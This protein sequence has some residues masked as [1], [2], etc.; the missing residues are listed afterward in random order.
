LLNPLISV[1]LFD[2]VFLEETNSY[3]EERIMKRKFIAIAMTMTMVMSLSACGKSAEVDEPAVE[4][5]EEVTAEESVEASSEEEK[6][7]EEQAAEVRAEGEALQ[8]EME[9]AGEFSV[10]TV[11][12]NSYVNEYFGVKLNLL[13]GYAFVDDEAL[14]QITGL[15]ADMLSDN[16]LLAKAIEDG[17]A[18][19]IAYAADSTGLNNVNV[20]VQSN[21]SLANAI[22]DEEAVLVASVGQ[23]KSALEAQGISNITYDVVEKEVAGEN[24]K[25]LKMNGEFNGIE[26]HNEMVNL[27]KGDYMLAFAATSFN[28]DATDAMIDAVESLN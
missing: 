15:T 13:D 8:A 27:Q 2:V 28:G 14:A 24:H 20:T 11:E 3:V 21:A 17:T 10:G 9:E 1:K 23:A 26:F 4:V 19:I 25:V 12:G 7:L 18:T 22:L 6:S 16:K 5:Q